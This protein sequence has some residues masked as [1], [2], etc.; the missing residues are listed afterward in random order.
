MS[1]EILSKTTKIDGFESVLIV[2]I[3]NGGIIASCYIH[4]YEFNNWF[5]DFSVIDD[6]KRQGIGTLLIKHMIQISNDA[7]QQ[8][9]SCRVEKSNTNALGFYFSNGFFISNEMDDGYI[10]TKKL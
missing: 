4:R 2:I 10:L 9:L 7:G 8:S 3:D 5:Q 6:K 1:M